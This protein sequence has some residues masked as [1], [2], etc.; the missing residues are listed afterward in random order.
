M[1]EVKTETTDKTAQTAA[2]AK[3]RA[4]LAARVVK[5]RDE[6]GKA[7]KD[8]EKATG[9]NPGQLRRLYNLGKAAHAAKES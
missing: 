5:L 2:D 6:Q 8:I 1:A 7:W 4:R 9:Q 3:A